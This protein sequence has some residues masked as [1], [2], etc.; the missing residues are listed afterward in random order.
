MKIRGVGVNRN[1]GKILS[2]PE[3][4]VFPPAGVFPVQLK[5]PTYS[6]RY[7]YFPRLHT[8]LFFTFLIFS[9]VLFKWIY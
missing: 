4:M 1:F 2:E 8:N 3:S 9:R 5:K 6:F 7:P